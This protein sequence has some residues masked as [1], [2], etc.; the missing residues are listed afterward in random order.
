MP[1]DMGSFGSSLGDAVDN[2]LKKT[3]NRVSLWF[4]GGI[5][6][7]MWTAVAGILVYR[8]VEGKVT[9][10]SAMVMILITAIG[11]AGVTSI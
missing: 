2:P 11:V 9:L 7:L 4:K 10:E 3:K 8:F 1:A 6:A 5:V